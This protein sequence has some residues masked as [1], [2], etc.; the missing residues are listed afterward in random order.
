[1]RWSVSLVAEGDRVVELEE[2][3]ELADAVAGIGG[4]ASGIGHHRRT[5]PSCWWRR[6]PATRRWSGRWRVRRGRRPGR[7]AAVADHPGRD[8]R[9]RRGARLWPRRRA[10][11]VPGDDPARLPGGLPVR[12][13]AGARRVDGAGAGRRCTP[14]STARRRRQAGRSTPCSTSATPTTSPPSGSRS[15]HPLAPCWLE[16]AGGDRFNLYIC[17]YEP[18][19]GA[20]FPPGADHPRAGRRLPARAATPSSTTRRG[21]TSGSAGTRRRRPAR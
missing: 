13:A 19:G 21:R 3:V 9:R 15:Q 20:P 17:T 11:G 16:R 10:A 18:P 5:A 7:P 6:R 8:H 12:G 4:I 2:V 1:M 14:S